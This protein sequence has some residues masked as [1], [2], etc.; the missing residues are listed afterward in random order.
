MNPRYRRQINLEEVGVAGQQKLL[1][2]KVLVIG[3]G[4]LGCPVL[5][6]LAAMGVGTL[7][8]C[9]FDLVDITNLHR[10][11]LFGA[12][13]I[14]KYK[15]NIAAEKI[16]VL[17]D[18][19]TVEVYLE[20]LNLNNGMNVLENYDLVIDCTD[21]FKTKFLIHDL[22]YYF[23]INLVQASIYQYDGTLNVFNFSRDHNNPCMRCL[24]P[25]Q[26]E[27]GCTQNCAEAGVLGVVPGVLGTMQAA[28]AIKLLLGLPHLNSGETLL[29]DL[30]SMETHRMKFDLNEDCPCC[31][32]KMD[33]ELLAR[34]SEDQ[35]LGF[36]IAMSD[37]DQFKKYTWI[38]IRTAEEIEA[39]PFE[40]N[41][42]FKVSSYHADYHFDKNE[43]Y[44]FFCQ[45]GFRSKKLVSALR[46]EGVNAFSLVGGID[47]CV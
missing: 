18:E 36:E 28:E 12:V 20:R 40:Y 38:D 35:K 8:I 16:R 17:N 41:D 39:R 31:H 1:D 43:E 4:G 13:D 44:L 37:K 6:Y 7:G 32:Q 25:K 9:D 21:N 45:K 26:P 14:G 15:A 19:I 2:A 30:I 3:A 23:S 24:W 10:Q 47:Q 22:C 33:Q 27:D 11:P 34:L 46:E 42:F 29:V 5:T